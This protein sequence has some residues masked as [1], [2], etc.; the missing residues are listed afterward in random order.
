VGGLLLLCFAG[1]RSAAKQMAVIVNQGNSAQNLTAVE[2]SKIFKCE[3]K[4]WGD[5]SA[6]TVVMRDP[7]GPDME[8]LLAQIYKVTP[9]ALKGFIAAHK[10]AIVIVDSNEAMI[11]AVHDI[12]GAI[13]VIDV[14]RINQDVKVL[15]IDG[16]LPVEYGYF[17]RGN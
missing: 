11:K 2:T 13:G 14:F 17:L 5:G 7:S 8:L 3:T 16:K 10:N 9:E 15:K 4:T 1:S 6:I 12:P